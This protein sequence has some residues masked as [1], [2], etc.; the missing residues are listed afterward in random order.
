[1]MDTMTDNKK[2]SH[3]KT[4]VIQADRSLQRKIGVGQLEP[5]LVENAQKIITDNRLDFAPYALQILEKLEQGLSK[6]RQAGNGSAQDA[7]L[8][9]GIVAPVMELKAHA[10]LFQYPL[11]TQLAGIMLSFLESVDKLDDDALD[12]VEAHHTTLHKITVM[13][14][15]GDGAQKGKELLLE[16]EDACTR[17]Y[18]KT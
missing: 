5:L 7:A 18:K 6:C 9:L 17:Y 12:I 10:A 3:G 2:A 8:K 13:R 16:L 4:R 15:T 11:I 14:M 1:M